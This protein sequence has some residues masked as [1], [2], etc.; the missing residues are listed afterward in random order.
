MNSR[1]ERLI[2]AYRRL[3]PTTK[4]IALIV[5]VVLLANGMY[6]FGL[7]NG[8]PISW[9]ADI[10]TKLCRV[11]CGRS[12][13][14]P[15]VG[16]V[17]QTLGHEAAMDLLHGHFPWWT[18]TQGLGQP[19]AGEM[20]SGALF[21]LTLLF[22]FSSGLLWFHISLEVIAGVSTYF[23]AR[24]LSL[25]VFF[26]TFAGILFSL[27]GT[28][29]W[30]GNSVLNPVAFMP[31]AILG[32][33]MVLDS[34]SSA[35]KRGWYILAIGLALSLYAGFPEVA[36]L[37]GLFVLAWAIVR[38]FS[39][40]RHQRPRAL[41]RLGLG[42][43]M[44]LILALPILVP[45]DDD[46]K[47]GFIGAHTAG[48]DGALALPHFA[49]PAFFDPY[50]Y[51][52]LFSNTK[53]I[54]MW[55]GIGGYFGASV[56]ALALVGLFGSKQ[57]PLRIFLGVWTL[58]SMAGTFNVLGIHKLWNLIPVVSRSSF[59]RYSTPGCELAIIILAA[60]GLYDFT[61]SVRAK[62]L[63]TTMTGLMILV[64]VWCI[65]EARSYNAG[66]H[67]TSREVHIVYIGLQAL[68]FIS[69][70]L[71]L[72]FGRLH[73]FRFTAF[74][75][76]L[77]VVGEAL[78]LFFVPQAEAPKQIT[79]DYAPIAYLQKNQGQE[80]FLDF[81]VL[82]PNWG[83]YFGINELSDIDL[84]FPKTFKNFIETDLRPGLTPGNQFVVKNGLV[85]VIEA[86]HSVINHLRQYEDASVKY[87]IM[88]TAVVLLPGLVKDGVK[89]VFS[90]PP[91]ASIY[92][93]PHPRAFFSTPSS[94]CTVSSTADNKATLD[95]PSAT[96][97]L[98]SELSMKGWK[99][100]VN[101]Q[102]V[103]ITTVHH[104]Y[105]EVSVPAGTSTVT[106]TFSPAHERDALIIGFLGGLFL[107][108]SF[109][110]ER[111][112]FI[113]TRRPPKHQ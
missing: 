60:F 64:L 39:V 1:V 43:L 57:R 18:Y 82:Y 65:F 37:D 104:V 35:T 30:L 95:C 101:G 110:N 45:F 58:L 10:S 55:G 73:R 62:R 23:L 56:C 70:F 3:S 77:V 22:A 84:P 93:L 89:Q 29:A 108:G 87:L 21:P 66:T 46:L 33:E 26:A 96:T 54:V 7:A 27:N 5:I 67:F 2:G 36:Y 72:V 59:E 63:L 75:L 53:V 80:R 42:G 14:D 47:A 11:T 24:R 12:A 94:S 28:Y 76:A 34:A 83:T 61:Q 50:V 107:I 106:Y 13:I 97:L 102:E 71:L 15:N 79:I 109:V 85:G 48:A 16:F 41:R 91:F 69:L 20:Q 4:A 86:E 111:R 105:Q 90:D 113:P 49:L 112:R 8:D 6:V 9:T 32:I 78:L 103:P 31:M 38:V 51:G 99:A 19:L 74:L 52:T 17:T 81:E 92:E 44:G 25:P 98:R 100:F 40:P 68:P 88:P